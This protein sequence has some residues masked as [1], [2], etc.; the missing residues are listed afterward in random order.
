L[1]SDKPSEI[2]EH[3]LDLVKEKAKYIDIA[4]EHYSAFYKPLVEEISGSQ[5]SCNDGRVL[6]RTFIHMIFLPFLGVA[7]YFRPDNRQQPLHTVRSN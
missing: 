2:S 7:F 3:T 6:Y 1:I 4:K 5:S